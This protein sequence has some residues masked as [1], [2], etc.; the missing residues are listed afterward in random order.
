VQAAGHTT[1]LPGLA[2]RWAGIALG[3]G[4]ERALGHGN[5]A[6]A[7]EAT[8]ARAP[9]APG[10]DR[11]GWLGQGRAQ[12]AGKELGRDVLSTKGGLRTCWLLGRGAD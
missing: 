1:H 12:S 8:R 6:V 11:A 10:H 9:C 4:W 3:C 5:R 2:L 7:G